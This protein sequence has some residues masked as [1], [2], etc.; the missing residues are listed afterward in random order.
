MQR[1]IFDL[2]DY[3][4][5]TLEQYGLTADTYGRT[6]GGLVCR[7]EQ[8]SVIVKEC[9]GTERKLEKQQELLEKLTGEGYRVDI[10]L[11]NKE[12]TL[13]TKD[14]DNIAYTLQKWFDGRECDTRSESDVRR[15]VGILAGIHRHMLLENEE[16]YEIPQLDET[17]IR[18]NQELRKIR[19]FIRK[20]HPGCEFEKIY[21]NK[22]EDYLKCGETALQMLDDSSYQM[23]RK[24]AQERGTVCHGEFNQHNVLL[25]KDGMAVTNFNR[26]SLDIQMGD[27]YHFMRKILEKHNWDSSLGK[28]MLKTYNSKKK[29][30][31]E[32]FFYLQVRFMYPDKFW[33]LADYYYTHSKVWISSKNTEKLKKLISQEEKRLDFVFKCFE[34]YPF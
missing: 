16:G 29:I 7:T 26:W 32:E 33:K 11:R 15:G 1:G 17:Y 14:R 9:K 8:G 13:V 6:R 28:E 19:K 12:G 18:H 31:R 25:M 24:D 21:L 34:R 3:G 23:L 10:F 20:K 5:S 30:S 22:A 4:L 27:L 2:Y